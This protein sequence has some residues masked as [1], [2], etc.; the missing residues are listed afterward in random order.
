MQRVGSSAL[1][2]PILPSSY[3]A[4]P[5]SS[6]H[7]QQAVSRLEA[8]VAA[9]LAGL[10][11]SFQ[12][13]TA[14]QHTAVRS[15]PAHHTAARAV[16]QCNY[17]PV[18]PARLSRCSSAPVLPSLPLTPPAFFPPFF[19]PVRLAGWTR[20]SSSRQRRT[21]SR[22]TITRP[23]APLPCRLLGAVC[24]LWQWPACPSP[25]STRCLAPSPPPCPPP[26]PHSTA[27]AS[28]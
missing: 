24:R 16:C 9:L 20:R 1:S 18:S 2:G 22:T 21:R 23:P 7:P 19:P 28:G 3:S 27:P 15:A 11:A 25:P 8:D 26:P 12:Q 6:L 13:L 10:S 4:A 17:L 5:S 14:P